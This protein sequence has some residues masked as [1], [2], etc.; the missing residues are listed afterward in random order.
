MGTLDTLG[1]KANNKLVSVYVGLNDPTNSLRGV[2]WGRSLAV[3]W[4]RGRG[5]GRR[6]LVAGGAVPRFFGAF[7]EELGFR[8]GGGGARRSVGVQLGGRGNQYA[9]VTV[10]T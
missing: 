3:V 6:H 2:F 9:Q 5:V 10:C 1:F 8:L 4:P 7:H